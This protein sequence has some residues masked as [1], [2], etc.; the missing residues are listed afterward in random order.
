[1]CTVPAIIFFFDD[2]KGG[3]CMWNQQKRLI[4]YIERINERQNLFYTIIDGRGLEKKYILINTG[5][6]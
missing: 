3:D 6:N 2:L 4:A 5:S 1:M